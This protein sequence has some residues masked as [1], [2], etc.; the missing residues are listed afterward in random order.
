MFDPNYR[1]GLDTDYIK[2]K[3]LV[4]F[5]DIDGVLAVYGYGSDGI[6][7]CSDKEF[8]EF[9]EKHDIYET[10]MGADFIKDYIKTFSDVSKNYVL[11]LS[12]TS[13]QDAQ[14]V[15]FINRMYPGMFLPE[16]ILFTRESDKSIITTEILTKKYNGLS[17]PHLFIDDDTR[18][19]YKLQVAGI[20]AVHISSLLLLAKLQ[21]QDT[22][23]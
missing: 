5:F 8:D 19:L 11:S 12:S 3:D 20:T 10:A 22:I 21:H 13:T 15:K 4:R 2:R 17:T 9:V 6:N 23:S 1:L 16:N 7:V 14:K 18:V